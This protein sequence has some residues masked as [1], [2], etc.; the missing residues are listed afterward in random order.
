MFDR[1]Y[2][3]D[4]ADHRRRVHLARWR[5]RISVLMLL[6]LTSAALLTLPNP[7][8]AVANG[9]DDKWKLPTDKV[10]G[11]LQQERSSSAHQFGDVALKGADKSSI[12]IARVAQGAKSVE[13][14]VLNVE[15]KDTASRTSSFTDNKISRIPGA[16]V[17]TAIGRFADLFITGDAPYIALKQRNDVVRVEV[18][19]S[20]KAPPPPKTEILSL[21]SKAVADRIVRGG[22]GGMT[23]KGV[24]IAVIDSGV[25][26]RHPDFITY[27]AAG[28]PTSRLLYLW[29]TATDYRRG[30]GS[31]APFSYPNKASI[32]TL[33]TRDQLTDALRR[34]LV[35]AIS[36]IPATDIDGHGTACASIAAGNG[37][38]DKGA[39][40]MKRSEL[41][42]VAPD[43]DIIGI[44]LGKEGLE[45]SYLLNAICEWLDRVAA[46]SPLVV[47]CSFGGHWDGHDGQTVGERHLSE[48]FP[49]GK[50]G[51]AIVA[52][53]G[54]EGRDPIHAEASFGDR[55]SA[56]LIR[57]NARAGAILNI[58]FDSA[59]EGLAIVPAANTPYK[60][61]PVDLNRLTGQLKASL[62]LPEGP[63][64]LWLINESGPQTKA[65][66]F[67]PSVG[68]DGAPAATFWSDVV[69]Y[70]T[71]VGG[72]GAAANVITV[73]SYDWNDNFHSGGSLVTLLEVC[74]GNDGKRSP[75]EIGKLSCYS[76]PGPTRLGK[77]K[78]EIVAPGE[79]YPSSYAKI[80]EGGSVDWPFP[81]DTNTNYA[82]MNGTSAA[83]PYTAGVIA[84]IFQKRPA[85]T[86]GEVRNLLTTKA[87]RDPFTG[88]VPNKHWGY[89]KLDL[90]AVE[91]IFGALK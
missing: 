21:E 50:S 4:R 77:V 74:P 17:L 22:Y 72:P 80:P 49:L 82:A 87:S 42:G 90:A 6:C 76:S 15:F 31:P 68:E 89:G 43:A 85:L 18:V 39:S 91:R 25:D 88:A 1:S 35:R 26:F 78:P 56:K 36:E 70:S 58:Y 62:Q 38:G 11:L 13:Y 51:R 9:Q 34:R 28:R 45:N 71:L 44:R 3:R 69:S 20:V 37:N 53:A 19:T 63:G 32:G 14:F 40:G 67:L 86:L 12:S 73:G 79:W 24:I 55:K 54:N 29:D 59:D 57:W 61:L 10:Q 46:Q 60:V 47:S 64:G 83:T 8:A 75:L 5:N 2:S 48:R 33:Y 81:I 84:L 27:D 66:L 16:F 7:G 23:G 52:A 65:H 30:R 41:V